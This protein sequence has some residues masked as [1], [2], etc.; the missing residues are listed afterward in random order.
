[1]DRRLRHIE[2][3]QSLSGSPAIR[4]V[5]AGRLRRNGGDI[6]GGCGGDG[7]AVDLY[8]GLALD[9]VRARR[10]IGDLQ[11]EAFGPHR[12]DGDAALVELD[13]AWRADHR[14]DDTRSRR[15]RLHA[16]ALDFSWRELHRTIIAVLA[17]VDGD[18]IHPHRIL[19]RHRRGV[20]QPHRIAVVFYL[21]R[22]LRGGRLGRR[23]WFE[24]DVG[25]GC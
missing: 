3:D 9:D 23:F 13:G 11:D 6:F 21:A 15:L 19:L 7:G 25:A 16:G 17:F 14:A 2:I 5:A 18:V 8:Q 20:R 22:T 4:T 24:A 12:D 10:D 1:Q